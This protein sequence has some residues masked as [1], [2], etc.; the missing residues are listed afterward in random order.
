MELILLVWMLGWM[1]GKMLGCWAKMPGCCWMLDARL[2]SGRDGGFL[3]PVCKAALSR[4]L[5][6]LESVCA[7]LPPSLPPGILSL[8]A[9]LAVSAPNWLPGGDRTS[10][11]PGAISGGRFLVRAGQSAEWSRRLMAVQGVQGG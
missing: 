10:P 8:P 1:L 11:P 3:C 5:A 9:S 7:R 6:G 4:L 2:P